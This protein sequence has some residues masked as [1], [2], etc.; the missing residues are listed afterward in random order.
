MECYEFA[1]A[2]IALEELLAV[3]QVDDKEA[4]D[5]KKASRSFQ[6]SEDTKEILIDPS[7]S[8][9]RMVRVGATLTPK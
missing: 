4:P 1:S 6:L 9:G 7:G 2:V 3:H 5:A 8:E